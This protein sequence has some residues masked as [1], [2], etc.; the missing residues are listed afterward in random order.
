MKPIII[1]GPC[2]AESQ[3]QIISAAA[4]IYNI[5][6]KIVFRAGLWKPRTHPGSF[7]GV[8]A[9]GLPWLDMVHSSFHMPVATEIATTEHLYLAA[10]HKIEYLWIG[11]RTS[12]NPFAVQMIADTLRILAQEQAY[13]P[14]V[15]IKN[16]INPDIELWEGAFERMQNAGVSK[17]MAVHRGFSHYAPSV[18]RNSPMWVIPLE[19][20]RRHPR[21]PLIC[22]PSHIAGRRDLIAELAQS[23]LDMG[24]DG[25]MIETHPRPDDALSDASQQITP[26]TL[27]DIIN[28]LKLRS[29]ISDDSELKSLR[30]SIDEC[31][32][33]L[34]RLLAR[35]M[36]ICDLIGRY[37]Q[38][39]NMTAVQMNR[40]DSII[41][42]R[43][44]QAKELG[45][46][47]DMVKKILGLIHQESVSR[48]LQIINRR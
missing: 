37:K 34:L 39:H 31:D 11:A 23:A 15:L 28:G 3:Q 45:L 41:K 27:A 22:D 33:E 38:T 12:A 20:K 18:F 5:S 16:P 2:S 43:M 4:A 21:L 17:L 44:A 1:A 24:F 32:D 29:N 13:Q 36:E 25:L 14:T 9:K 40:H 48:Q 26:D 47:Q 6:D 42:Q 8:G 35:R 19:M 7:E 10:N 30:H 46:N